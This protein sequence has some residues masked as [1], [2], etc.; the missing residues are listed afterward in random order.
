LQLQWLPDRF[1]FN[2][3]LS[4]PVFSQFSLKNQLMNF[5]T[6]SVLLV[7][8]LFC[9]SSTGFSQTGGKKQGMSDADMKKLQEQMKE[10]DKLPNGAEMKKM[11]QEAMNRIEQGQKSGMMTAT[12]AS[13]GFPKP[14]TAVLA[15][16]PKK[17]FTAAELKEYVAAI[18]Q[19]ILEK[20]SDGEKKE[21]AQMIEKYKDKLTLHQLAVYGWYFAKSPMEAVALMAQ[22]CL[23]DMSDGLMLNN[24]SALLILGGAPEKAVPILRYLVSKH[25]QDPLVANNMGQ[26]YAALG[27]KDT[28]KTHLTRA[29]KVSKH[30]QANNTLAQIAKAEGNNTK[31]AEH[32]AASLESSY[33]ESAME[34]LEELGMEDKYKGFSGEPELPDYFNEYKFKLPR[35][36]MIL[37]DAAGVKA[38][39]ESFRDKLSAESSKLSSVQSEYSK[40]GNRQM[41]QQMKSLMDDPR[42]MSSLVNGRTFA[43]MTARTL[44]KRLA[45]LNHMLEDEQ[46]KK[47]VYEKELTE[48]TNAYVKK[49]ASI[50]EIYEA[51]IKKQPCGEG[52]GKACAEVERLRKQM[53]I[54]IDKTTNEYLANY[55]TREHTQRMKLQRIYLY[56]FY[57][58]SRAGFLTAPNQAMGNSVYYEAARQYVSRL[59]DLVPPE[60][61]SSYCIPIGHSA[62]SSS[63]SARWNFTCPVDI[64]LPFLVGKVNINCEAISI[65][66]GEGAKFSF[67]QNFRTKQSTLSIGI[68]FELE[69]KKEDEG[70]KVEGKLTMGQT[71]YI[72]HD[73]KTGIYDMGM[74][75]GAGLSAGYSVP[76]ILSKTGVMSDGSIGGDVGWRFG[77][78]SGGETSL[79]FN[80]GPFKGVFTPAAPV[81]VNPNIGIYPK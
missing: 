32:A 9:I 2:S 31:A 4:A 30:P 60:P 12:A 64:N 56:L 63:L 28:A 35:A 80:E 53:C 73:G 26:A 3:T 58:N 5:L 68:G 21:I 54:E 13:S 14:N 40:A 78:N 51:Q 72:T 24:L 38:E 33:S 50:Q 8:C 48:I 42:K 27:V 34:I 43:A 70:F 29:A 39:K 61:K 71:F 75:F 19:K 20:S 52:N 74:K 69:G 81:Q 79:E 7:A 6:R 47:P 66:A 65:K 36:Q 49:A 67:S 11:A 77:I 1:H 55:G 57:E 46:R 59:R 44:P 62:D 18:Y 15:T 17:T 23:K 10:L 37:S 22:A 16:I 41:E 45:Y 25:P 76:P